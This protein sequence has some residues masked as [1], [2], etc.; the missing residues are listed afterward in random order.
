MSSVWLI[1]CGNKTAK[2]VNK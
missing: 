2:K 1:F